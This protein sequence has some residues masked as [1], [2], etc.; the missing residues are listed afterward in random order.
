VGHHIEK[1]QILTLTEAKLL[2]QL[3]NIY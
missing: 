3:Q 1:C 2:N